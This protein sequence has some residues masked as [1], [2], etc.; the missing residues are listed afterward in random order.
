MIDKVAYLVQL[1]LFFNQQSIYEEKISSEIAIFSKSAISELI[2][3]VKIDSF[4]F[5]K[6]K[7]KKSG[8]S[9]RKHS[10]LE[11]LPAM[12][13]AFSSQAQLAR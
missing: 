12:C 9:A 4:F 6:Y 3:F 13:R 1:F 10:L 8:L 11:S 2:Y 7:T 5:C